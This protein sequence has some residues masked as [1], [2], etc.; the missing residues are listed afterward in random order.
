MGD[1][2]D[3]QTK[4]T[5]T[6]DTILW[7][8]VIPA[9]NNTAVLDV[10][11]YN[12][13]V[14]DFAFS[15]GHNDQSISLAWRAE[16]GAPLTPQT[17][18]APADALGVIMPTVTAPVIGPALSI[19]NNGTEDRPVTVLGS[20]RQVAGLVG[21]GYPKTVQ[22]NS[23][24]VTWTAGTI[25]NVGGGYFGVQGW[26]QLSARCS[27]TAMTGELL[28]SLGNGSGGFIDIP[29]TDTSLMHSMNG[30]LQW[31]GQ[32]ILPWDMGLLRWL[33]TA[34]GNAIISVNAIPLGR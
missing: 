1:L 17:M 13:L 7:T 5:Q 33:P 23:G 21:V 10:S 18:T 26:V 12:S 28:M 16:D 20:Q 4:V 8:G 24:L 14:V 22:A 6:E 9:N 2:P 34:N 11:A 30:G 29:I 15:P 27:N 19:Y 3:W 32:V 25:Q 31:Y